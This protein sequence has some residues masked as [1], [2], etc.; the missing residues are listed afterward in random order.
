MYASEVRPLIQETLLGLLAVQSMHGYELKRS[1]DALLPPAQSVNVGQVYTALGRLE[2]DGDVEAEFVPQNEHADRR[3]YTITNRGRGRLEQWL[4]IPVQRGDLRDEVFLKLALVRRTRPQSVHSVLAVQR[5][6]TLQQI[7]N[8]TLLVQ[9]VP[10]QQVEM[11]LLLRGA[12][13]H[14]EADLHWLDLWEDRIDSGGPR[15]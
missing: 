11:E 1:L 7:Q 8:L 3:V 2:K 13:L 14:L 15:R 9:R 4:V 12:I 10:V 5:A 6:E